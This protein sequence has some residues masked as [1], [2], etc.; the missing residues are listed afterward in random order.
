VIHSIFAGYLPI[1]L[2]L[3]ILHLFMISFCAFSVIYSNF[4]SYYHFSDIFSD[5]FPDIFADI[6]SDTFSDIF[7]DTFSGNFADIFSDTFSDNFSNI[8]ADI[9]SNTFSDNFSYCLFMLLCSIIYILCVFG[10][11]GPM[12]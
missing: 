12:Y 3:W 4:I 1:I 7:S 10:G 6:F 2:L 5:T 8:F 11:L 9:F